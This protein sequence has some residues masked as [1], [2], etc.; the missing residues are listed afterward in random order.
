[1]T[2]NMSEQLVSVKRASDTCKCAI[3]K[4]IQKVKS[5]LRNNK[6]IHCSTCFSGL[7]EE[8]KNV[9]E[10]CEKRKLLEGRVNSGHGKATSTQV[11]SN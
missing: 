8:E 10:M 5:V 3:K 9:R 1:M 4:A 11:R 6:N 2:V 7:R